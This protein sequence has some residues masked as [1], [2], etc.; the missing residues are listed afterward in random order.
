MFFL[1]NKHS[2]FE[3]VAEVICPTGHMES[4]IENTSHQENY[5]Y[6]SLGNSINFS[7]LELNQIKK[8]IQSKEIREIIFVLSEE[9][10]IITDAI[11]NQEF[12]DIR[13]LKRFYDKVQFQ[14]KHLE[15]S[16]QTPNP[17][18]MLLSTFLNEKIEKLK[19]GLKDLNVGEITIV[20]KIFN[21]RKLEF[22]DISPELIFSEL[23]VFN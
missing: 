11:G 20:G 19:E 14:K 18:Y 7:K 12:S 2:F 22:R 16:W 9:N 1:R 6:S 4:V 8:L 23:F 15:L 13:G 21:K 5:F 10:Q 17:R 3:K